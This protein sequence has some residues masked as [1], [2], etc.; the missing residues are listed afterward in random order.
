MEERDDKND[1][2]N[3]VKEIGSVPHANEYDDIWCA[4]RRGDRKAVRA[5]INNGA[6]P[7]IEDE[8]GNPPL[9][10]SLLYGHKKICKDLVRE[11]ANIHSVPH[12][13]VEKIDDL[14]KYK[15]PEKNEYKNNRTPSIIEEKMKKIYINNNN[16]NRNEDDGTASIYT[17]N[18][19][20]YDT[21]SIA[22]SM[23]MDTFSLVVPK[24][25]TPK[26]KKV[27]MSDAL[28]EA[29]ENM[30]QTKGEEWVK[31][32]N[33][34]AMEKEARVEKK[35]WISKVNRAFWLQ[36]RELHERKWMAKHN[37]VDAEVRFTDDQRRELRKWFETLDT[38]GSGE[39]SF[40]ELAG[41]LLSTGIAT[42]QREVRDIIDR[43]KSPI[44][45]GIDFEAFMSLLK[46]SKASQIRKLYTR[47]KKETLDKLILKA[48]EEEKHS[49][50]RDAFDKL[51]RQLSD[52]ETSANLELDSLI[53]KTRRDKIIDQLKTPILSYEDY[54]EEEHEDD[55]D[56]EALSSPVPSSPRN[57]IPKSSHNMNASPN[58]FKKNLLGHL[59]GTITKVIGAQQHKSR[60]TVVRTSTM[61]TK[62]K[63][64]K[65]NVAAVEYKKKLKQKK[66]AREKLRRLDNLR[67]L[68]RVV[69]GSLLSGTRVS[70]F[71]GELPEQEVDKIK[72]YNS[73][74]QLLPTLKPPSQLRAMERHRQWNFWLNRATGDFSSSTPRSEEEKS[75][76]P[77]TERK[78][79]ILG[80][81]SPYSYHRSI[82]TEEA[83]SGDYQAMEEG[84]DIE[85]LYKDGDESAEEEEEEEDE[86]KPLLVLPTTPIKKEIGRSSSLIM[87]NGRSAIATENILSPY[88]VNIERR[89]SK[90]L[91]PS[92][93][94]II[95]QQKYKHRKLRLEALN[96]SEK[97]RKSIK[98]RKLQKTQ[99]E[100]SISNNFRRRSSSKKKGS[101]N[102]ILQHSMSMSN[103]DDDR[104]NRPPAFN[105][106]LGPIE[107]KI[108]EINGSNKVV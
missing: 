75:P 42:T 49:A 1:H 43:H 71:D 92:R 4:A 34:M 70:Y 73:F 80:G 47:A 54:E 21:S 17:S 11:G 44:S 37:M 7:D 51:R 62:L 3:N 89:Y 56:D 20:S 99:S 104:N 84:Y 85:D 77:N 64:K 9:Y 79:D 65:T 29:R 39:I 32:L 97:R 38:D 12:I 40:V 106:T 96:D 68:Q 101:N 83:Q 46:P 105:I 19:T 59:K 14:Q 50:A 78:F 24:I 23:R 86:V 87:S 26:K 88:Q 74:S 52:A 61:A 41:P 72:V 18:N 63:E 25:R 103:V 36:Q 22:S 10:Y 82:I 13:T 60:K 6:D 95:R 94:D 5:F 55:N 53:A 91:K 81:E 16:N 107:S 58:K 69:K 31:K 66:I 93:A 30:I 2:V 98:Q 28:K 102:N 57:A 90:F 8:C 48:E 100:A 76:V 27:Q 15:L 108:F 35:K 33:K 45:G 67:C